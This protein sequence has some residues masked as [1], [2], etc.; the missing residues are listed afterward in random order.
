MYDADLKMYDSIVL[1]RV[2]T[3]GST[4][5]AMYT[6]N[7]NVSTTGAMYTQNTNG[8]TT[9]AMY[10]Q[11]TN[12]STTGAMY[13]HNTNGSTTGAMYTQNTNGSTTG[14]M[15]THNTNDVCDGVVVDNMYTYTC[16]ISASNSYSKAVII[17]CTPLFERW[18][19][20][21]VTHTYFTSLLN[22]YLWIMCV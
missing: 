16:S 14:A 22:P 21:V 4:T 20:Y 9:G 1:F 3:N 19:A 2:H 6:Q 15:Y 11:N 17:Q 10:T 7:T 5:G 8:S 18:V 12:G 13:T